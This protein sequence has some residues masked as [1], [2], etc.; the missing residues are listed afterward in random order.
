MEKMQILYHE[1]AKKN[2]VYIVSACGFDSIPADLGLVFLK[3]EFQ[4]ELNSAE[5]FLETWICG[6]RSVSSCTFSYG[7]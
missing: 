4:G 3:N 2:E 7:C 5:I 1:E 6:K